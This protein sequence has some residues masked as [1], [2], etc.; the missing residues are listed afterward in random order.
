[1]VAKGVTQTE[2]ARLTGLGRT[3]VSRWVTGSRAMKAS[4]LCRL[5]HALGEP[6]SKV[7]PARDFGLL[8]LKEYQAD[9]DSEL[10][11]AEV[12]N[13]ICV[14]MV[15]RVALD[16]NPAL[17]SLSTRILTALLD[18]GLNGPNKERDAELLAAAV[19]HGQALVLNIVLPT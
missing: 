3:D 18:R 8:R 2:L 4:T 12:V 15:C 9:H 5:L 16:W 10:S 1:M 13:R 19:E 14:E 6:I 17:Y 11:D 7:A